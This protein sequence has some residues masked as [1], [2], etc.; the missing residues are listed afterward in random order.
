MN[1]RAD[2]I[3]SLF[4]S[5]PSPVLSAD[6]TASALPRVASGSIRSLQNTFS[7]VERENEELRRRIGVGQTIVEIDPELI[8]PSPFR[9]RFDD[10]DTQSFE[11]LK[12]SI[13]EQGQA[14]PV[15]LREEPANSG[16][17][18]IA[19]GHRRVRAVREL[20]LP[21]KAVVRL[22]SDADLAVAQGLENA[23]REDL[24][25]IE[26]AAFALRLEEAGHD[27]L[28]TQRALAIDRAE[29]SKLIAVARNI[30]ADLVDAIGRAP[31]IGRGRWLALVDA[32]SG[33][34]A[35]KRVAQKI[36]ETGFRNLPS[37]DRFLTVLA[38]ALAK[39]NQP[40]TGGEAYRVVAVAD[41]EVARVATSKTRTVISIG[42]DA[43]GDAFAAFVEEKLPE[44]F[45]AFK[46]NRSG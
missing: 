32:L 27:R 23:A 10:Q 2:T 22:L 26:R 36:A 45:A 31:G 12:E 37:N 42:H 13:R 24:T 11:A 19:Y 46:A 40:R 18:Q 6:N 4:A 44:M 5:T 7:D 1:K 38:A 43:N 33:S 9:D 15:L 3:K 39:M 17:Y 30:P 35:E 16:R 8:T 28:V 29:A 20:G 25:F 34:G 41:I 21:V 14:V